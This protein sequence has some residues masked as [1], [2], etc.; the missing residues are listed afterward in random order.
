VNV[1]VP[2]S[3]TSHSLSRF[4]V[5]GR[6]ST[7][8]HSQRLS[9]TVSRRTVRLSTIGLSTIGLSTVR[10]S[11]C[12]TV[13]PSTVRPSTVRLSDCPTVDCP[14]VRPSTVDRRKS[15]RFS[16]LEHFLIQSELSHHLVIDA[17][18]QIIIVGNC[19]YYLSSNIRK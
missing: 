11:D 14:T 2:V 10:L 5:K 15:L 12:P 1:P 19:F 16:G 8:R 7:C 4:C 6:P 9:R 18:L 13:R 3:V 17:V